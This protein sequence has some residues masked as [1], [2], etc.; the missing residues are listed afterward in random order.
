MPYFNNH[1]VSYTP[2]LLHSYTQHQ[3]DS[4]RCSK[5]FRATTASFNQRFQPQA[6]HRV[7]GTWFP[8]NFARSQATV[9]HENRKSISFTASSNQQLLKVDVRQPLSH[10]LTITSAAWPQRSE[11]IHHAGDAELDIQPSGGVFQ[12]WCAN[13]SAVSNKAA[14][15]ENYVCD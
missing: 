2:T 5:S 3:C 13:L 6:H 10:L 9:V 12:P 8:V 11:N 1:I 4:A 15:T 14:H 7:S